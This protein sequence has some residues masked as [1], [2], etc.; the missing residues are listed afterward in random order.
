MIDLQGL[1]LPPHSGWDDSM[2]DAEPPSNKES[3]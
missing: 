2:D 1:S 3:L